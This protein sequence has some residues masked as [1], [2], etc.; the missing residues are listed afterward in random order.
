MHK[1][2]LLPLLLIL[3]FGLQLTSCSNMGENQQ[4][5]SITGGVI[6]GLLGS[7][8]GG[9]SGRTAAI[10]GGSIIGSMIG[11]NVGS[12]MDDANRLRVAHA[13]ENT[14]LNHSRSW[15][16]DDTG[17]RYTVVPTKT[18][19]QHGK[20]CRQYTTSILVDG[21]L[22]N[23]KGTACRNKEGNWIIVN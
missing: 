23:A 22:K 1:N 4:V 7:Q 9:G 21:E 5:G 8:V 14:R 15:V 19:H 12:Q 6:G 16:D 3:F 2:F 10:I 17:Y 13:L 18:Y 20:L 11:G